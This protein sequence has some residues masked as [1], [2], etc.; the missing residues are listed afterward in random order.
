MTTE[1]KRRFRLGFQIV[2]M[3]KKKGYFEENCQTDLLLTGKIQG[4][5]VRIRQE[6]RVRAFLCCV[7]DERESVDRDLKE[8]LVDADSE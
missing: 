7:C 6:V 5:G 1:S 2:L 8:S 4:I 3:S